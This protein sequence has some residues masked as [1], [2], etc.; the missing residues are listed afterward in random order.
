[1]PRIFAAFSRLFFVFARVSMIA[2]F[3]PIDQNGWPWGST[4]NQRAFSL[5]ARFRPSGSAINTY[6]LVA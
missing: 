6:R 3:L 2:C 1:M 4:K 5:S